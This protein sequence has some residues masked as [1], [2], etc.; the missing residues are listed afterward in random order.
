MPDYEIY[1]SA[2]SY[3]RLGP[4]TIIEKELHQHK[5]LL[6]MGFPVPKL[7][8]SGTYNNKEYYIEESMGDKPIA[9]YFSEDITKQGT[10]SKENFD[11]FLNLVK[12]YARAS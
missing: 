12:I 6:K 4:Q 5:Q 1:A 9:H 2:A 11:A 3:I 7:V 10:I 8:S